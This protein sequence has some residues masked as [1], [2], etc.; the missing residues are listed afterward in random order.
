MLGGRAMPL[1]VL[2]KLGDIFRKC[3]SEHK[4]LYAS[5]MP[6]GHGVF[7]EIY[8]EGDLHSLWHQRIQR[9]LYRP[10]QDP[11]EFAET[12]ELAYPWAKSDKYVLPSPVEAAPASNDEGLPPSLDGA[13]D[14]PEQAG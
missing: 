14:N 10:G 6:F 3:E 5:R 7:S 8:E 9:M 4:E 2:R 1:H 12:I 11:H 13:V